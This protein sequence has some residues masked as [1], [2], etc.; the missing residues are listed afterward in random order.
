MVGKQTR[1]PKEHKN[2]SVNGARGRRNDTRE[3]V[4]SQW[5]T[6]WFRP[7]LFFTG[8]LVFSPRVIEKNDVV[9]LQTMSLTIEVRMVLTIIFRD[10]SEKHGGLKPES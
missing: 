9:R 6:R 2:A 3:G 4:V 1:R 8:I 5:L 7:S 10:S